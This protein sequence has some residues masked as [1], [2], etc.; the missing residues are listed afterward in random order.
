MNDFRMSSLTE[1][2]QV[3]RRAYD[4]ERSSDGR[5]RSRTTRGSGI[6]LVPPRI[7]SGGRTP[8][9]T[10]PLAAPEWH[11]VPAR[12]AQDL[13]PTTVATRQWPMRTQGVLLTEEV[14]ATANAAIGVACYSKHWPDLA[15]DGKS[16]LETC[17]R[18][19]TGKKYTGNEYCAGVD[20]GSRV[21]PTAESWASKHAPR[22]HPS[23]VTRRTRSQLSLQKERHERWR[24][25]RRWHDDDDGVWRT[26]AHPERWRLRVDSDEREAA[27]EHIAE[28]GGDDGAERGRVAVRSGR[29]EGKEEVI[30]VEEGLQKNRGRAGGR[31]VPIGELFPYQEIA[32]ISN[33]YICYN[34]AAVR[35]SYTRI[36]GRQTT[37]KIDFETPA[38]PRESRLTNQSRRVAR[39]A[40]LFRPSHPPPPSAR[41]SLLRTLCYA[42]SAGLQASLSAGVKLKLSGSPDALRVALPASQR[43]VR[44]FVAQ[45]LLTSAAVSAHSLYT[46]VPPHIDKSKS[47]IPRNVPLQPSV[48]VAFSFDGHDA[49]RISQ[50]LSF[51]QD[52]GLHA[53]TMSACLAGYFWGFISVMHTDDISDTP[54]RRQRFVWDTRRQR[55]EYELDRLS[56]RRRVSVAREFQDS[57]PSLQHACSAA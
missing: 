56:P 26:G 50:S 55:E 32:Y 15:R 28:R 16:A 27:H 18:G 44:L 10:S 49:F 47:S 42:I 46:T 40:S 54:R 9:V 8:T 53:S 25:G 45:R 22:S 48:Q 4:P 39:R 7:V 41:C 5:D 38:S 31:G 57:V 6:T 13:R 52:P 43:P 11:P 29:D 33:K 2:G 37:R 12:L 1:N 17:T 19:L 30:S 24:R 35:P 3:T 20:G 23:S 34:F 51:A 36:P 21:S 14:V